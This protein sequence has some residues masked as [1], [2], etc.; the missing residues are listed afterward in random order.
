MV[1]PIAF[2]PI[3]KSMCKG[4]IPPLAIPGC[5][6]APSGIPGAVTSVTVVT[7]VP[8]AYIHTTSV[9]A[10]YTLVLCTPV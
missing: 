5:G 1:M 10:L 7:L 4:A 6:C 3:P 8:G 9:S 2:L